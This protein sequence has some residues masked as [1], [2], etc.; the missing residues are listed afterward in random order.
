MVC[1]SFG[2]NMAALNTYLEMGNLKRRDKMGELN[3]DGRIILK[4]FL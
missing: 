4:L 3:E 1:Y 2:G